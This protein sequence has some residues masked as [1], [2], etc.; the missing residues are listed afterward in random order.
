VRPR[1]L[2]S[3][4][5][6]ALLALSPTAG[7]DDANPLNFYHGC[8][9]NSGSLAKPVNLGT[10]MPARSIDL[11]ATDKSTTVKLVINHAPPLQPGDDGLMR[12]IIG[13]AVAPVEVTLHFLKE[14]PAGRRV[15]Q[16]R[17]A[18]LEVGLSVVVAAPTPE[19]CVPVVGG[20][21]TYQLLVTGK[22]GKITAVVPMTRYEVPTIPC[23]PGCFPTGTRIETPD[24]PRAIE[25]IRAG[26]LVLNIAPDGKVSPIKVASVFV[27]NSTLVEVETDRGTLVTT[28]KQPLCLTSGEQRCAGV[29]G[30]GAALR[31][32]PSGIATVKE[33]RDT[34][35]P[36]RIFNLVLETPGVFVANGYHVKSKSPPTAGK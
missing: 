28:C 20:G 14:S 2:V 17:G 24:G 27:G 10:G 32:W 26:D 30:N 19:M 9:L 12:G 21:K 1:T 23:H 5:C 36:A 29:L 6:A 18:K 3:Y 11:L 22:T 8:A 31:R 13:H 35:K 15:Y 4:A 16:L 7:A 25:T 33:V 34:G